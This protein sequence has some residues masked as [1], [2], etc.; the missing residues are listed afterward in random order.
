MANI[1]RNYKIFNGILFYIVW[2]A[3]IYG[4]ALE[5]EMLGVMTG[6]VLTALHF[7]LSSKRLKDLIILAVYLVIAVFGDWLLIQCKVIGYPY[8]TY[9]ITTLGVPLWVIMLYVSFSTTINHSLVLIH[10][11]PLLCSLG[12]GIGG[13]IS[14]YFSE[15][16]GAILLP[17]GLGSLLGLTLYW[18]A[19]LLFSK[20]MHD[21]LEM[22]LA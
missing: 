18:F 11:Y 12:G 3:C 17:L 19:I 9:D 8:V 13:A 16:I 4:A 22:R 1:I 2:Y 14:F 10:R 5:F 15:K 21:Q 6:V 20:W 7:C